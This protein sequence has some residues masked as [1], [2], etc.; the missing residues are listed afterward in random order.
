[1]PR[2]KKVVLPAP[3]VATG[4]PSLLPAIRLLS[5]KQVTAS[6]DGAPLFEKWITVLT[7]TQNEIEHYEKLEK[8]AQSLTRRNM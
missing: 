3:S 5:D 7:K 6:A 2:K 1:M 8:L 4:Y